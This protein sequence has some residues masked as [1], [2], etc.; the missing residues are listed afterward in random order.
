MA[1]PP[2]GQI[3]ERDGKQGR[4]FALRF[5]AYGKREYVTTTAT[6]RAEAEEQLAY[7]LAQVKRGTW[8][9]P[10][11]PETPKQEPT[12]HEFASEWLAARELEGLAERTIADLKWSLELH[13]LPHFASYRLSEITPQLVDRY[14][15]A[16]V[17]EREAIAAARAEAEA[18]GER[19][20]ERGLSNSSIN[21]TLSD[22]AQ[23]L[24]TAVEYGLLAANP[25]SG[26]RRR[27]KSTKPARPRPTRADTGVSRRGTRGSRADA[28]RHPRRHRPTH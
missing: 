16:K 13:L 24:E 6:N 20:R 21:H 27:L 22:L 12:F 8:R 3:V 11:A 17:R 1:R 4:T 28:S 25:A 9:P 7:I 18:K 23:V 10:A 2:S 15:V 19:C 14:K 5:R 26:K